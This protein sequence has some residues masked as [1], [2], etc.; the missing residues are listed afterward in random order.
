MTDKQSVF[1]LCC[2]IDKRKNTSYLSNNCKYDVFYNYVKI[3]NLMTLIRSGVFLQTLLNAFRRSHGSSFRY[4]MQESNV[5]PPHISMLSYPKLSICSKI[6]SMSSVLILVAITDCWPSRKS[7]DASFTGP[8][9]SVPSHVPGRS[10]VL[11]LFQNPILLILSYMY[12]CNCSV[13][14]RAY[15]ID[16]KIFM[17]VF[18]KP[19]F[20]FF[21]SSS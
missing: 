11:A 9:F 1:L 20:S 10:A 19:S 4:R 5:A 21:L 7:T 2:K 15:G 14:L 3:L 6:G 8:Y 16:R 18:F 13:G 17:S 12:D